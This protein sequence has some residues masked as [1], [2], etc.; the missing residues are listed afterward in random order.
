MTAVQNS[1]VHVNDYTT[2]DTVDCN[3][4]ILAFMVNTGGTL[5]ILTPNGVSTTILV[6]AGVIYPIAVRRFLATGT[7]SVAGIRGLH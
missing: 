5:A 2:S 4:P 6:T 3:P 1:Y 7:V